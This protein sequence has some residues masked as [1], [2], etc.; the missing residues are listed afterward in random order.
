MKKTSVVLC[1]LS[2]LAGVAG[3]AMS[4]VAQYAQPAPA[5][6]QPAVLAFPALPPSDSCKKWKIIGLWKLKQMY[7]APEG[8][9]LVDYK[10]HPFQYYL[11]NRNNTY[12]QYVAP[13]DE[14]PGVVLK[15]IDDQKSVLRQF[16][17]DKSGFTFLYQN[18]VATDTLACFVVASQFGA[19]NAGEL[20]LM[21]PEGRHPGRLVSVY[22]KI[23]MPPK[24]R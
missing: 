13:H 18:G 3:W 16:V 22:D 19:F 10:M 1:V 8:R 11:F 2:F 14:R 6:Q 4:A 9:E 15:A 23:W 20:L 24:G 21:P 5:Q 7:E 17:V 12:G